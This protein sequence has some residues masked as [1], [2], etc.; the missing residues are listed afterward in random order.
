V[1]SSPFLWDRVSLEWSGGE[2]PKLSVPHTMAALA[3]REF[4]LPLE[5]WLLHQ[6][7]FDAVVVAGPADPVKGGTDTH[8]E[9]GEVTIVADGLM[10]V[11]PALLRQQMD[12]LATKAVE[13]ANSIGAERQ[14]KLRHFRRGL[15]N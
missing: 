15:T 14:E 12:L 6:R 7:I 9:F 8:I 2:K 3:C 13:L 11:E 10:D 1:A 4:E 5:E